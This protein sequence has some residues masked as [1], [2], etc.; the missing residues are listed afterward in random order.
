MILIAFGANLPGPDGSPPQETCLR[1]I[2]AI[3]AIPGLALASVSP[4]YISAPVPIS[5][6]PPYINGVLRA[7]GVIDPA[8]L[9]AR[10]LEI[11]SQFGRR[12]TGLNAAR[13]L[14]LDIIAMGPVGD[15]VR[16]A[17]DPVL[18]HPRAHERAFVLIPLADIAPEWRHPILGR[19]A[20]EL[21]AALPP[22]PI[23][24]ADRPAR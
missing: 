24:R 10:L 1:A 15:L 16:A 13:S 18:P 14:D 7:E 8:E 20:A 22:Q 6:Q 9:L 23:E 11:E 19:T 21:A 2:P 4:L 17:P 12:R 5:D 3:A